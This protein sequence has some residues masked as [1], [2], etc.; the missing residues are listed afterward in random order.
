[1]IGIIAAAIVVSL[2]L[3]LQET[4]Q[5]CSVSPGQTVVRWKGMYWFPCEY[6]WNGWCLWPIRRKHIT[7]K[8]TVTEGIPVRNAEGQVIPV[9]G[10]KIREWAVRDAAEWNAI[11]NQP[12]Q[13]LRF[14]DYEPIADNE[15]VV[16]VETGTGCSITSKPT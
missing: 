3:P 11:E 12:K 1:M 6:S 16:L 4:G 13:K 5:G 10:G 14:P 9:A 15:Y 7:Y 8:V 2:A